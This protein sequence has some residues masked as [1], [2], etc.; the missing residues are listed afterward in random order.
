M[1]KQNTSNREEIFSYLIRKQEYYE[2]I[3][4]LTE[5]QEE[6][7]QSNNTKKLNLITT[8]K[9]NYI[10]EIKRLDKRNLK[11][12]EELM[13][14]KN[15][16]T[17]DKR[18]YPLLEQLRSIITKIRNYDHDSISQL[19]SSVKDTKSRLNTI[20]KRMRAQQSLRNQ[21]IN[22]PRFVDIFQ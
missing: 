3:L 12:Y 5:K 1:E 13:A 14:D 20:N 15:S 17:Q 19:H 6:A 22:T 10:K 4:E 21:G 7:I 18:L 8:E 2:K 16:L 9:E 11:M